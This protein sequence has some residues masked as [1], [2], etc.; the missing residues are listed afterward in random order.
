MLD[1]LAGFNFETNE[2]D[3]NQDENETEDVV[4]QNHQS[5][6]DSSYVYS[7]DEDEDAK[8]RVRPPREDEK[9]VSSF[10]SSK[11]HIKLGLIRKEAPDFGG[12][13]KL[14]FAKE[15]QAKIKFK[16]KIPVAVVTISVEQHDIAE[17]SIVDLHSATTQ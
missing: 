12:S 8:E 5:D 10:D 1:L 16:F 3:E 7:V 13:F 2:Y 14:D 4:S 17:T 11:D 6:D 9:T 15:I